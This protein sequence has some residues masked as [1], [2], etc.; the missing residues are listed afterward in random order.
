[1]LIFLNHI[2]ILFLASSGYIMDTILHS[3]CLEK[4]LQK[5]NY[6]EKYYSEYIS[7]PTDIMYIS[8]NNDF[9]LYFLHLVFIRFCFLII[10]IISYYCF[11]VCFFLFLN[12]FYP[13]FL[14]TYILKMI[15]K[16][17]ITQNIY[18][19]FIVTYFY[20]ILFF[21]FISFLI[22]FLYIKKLLIKKI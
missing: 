22:N 17:F 18:V 8:I 3:S 20:Y 16:I 7:V 12:V 15:I 4:L 5:K 13:L 6:F 14:K 9:K 19:K 11:F 10:K 21:I 2:I 1:M